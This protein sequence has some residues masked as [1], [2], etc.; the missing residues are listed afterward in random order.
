M[1]SMT[2]SHSDEFYIVLR[3][4]EARALVRILMYEYINYEDLEAREVVTRICKF[5]QNNE[6]DRK[7]RPAAQ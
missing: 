6:L 4:D 7:H 2:T 5:V 1:S 3:L